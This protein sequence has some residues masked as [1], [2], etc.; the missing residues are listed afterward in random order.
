M[1]GVRA[2]Q[3]TENRAENPTLNRSQHT[4]EA[5]RGYV[6]LMSPSLRKM[7]IQKGSFVGTC[8]MRGAVLN[9]EKRFPSEMSAA[10]YAL[11]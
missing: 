6:W 4:A 11:R 1:R 3:S 10:G 2:L 5:I 9:D 8:A 7:D